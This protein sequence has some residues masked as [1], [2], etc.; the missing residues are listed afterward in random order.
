MVDRVVGGV[1]GAKGTAQPAP[2][3][4]P[5]T[6]ADFPG[7]YAERMTDD[8]FALEDR[9]VEY[10]DARRDMAYICADNSGAH[11]RPPNRVAVLM[12]RVALARGAAIECYGNI[13]L[14]QRRVEPDADEREEGQSGARGKSGKSRSSERAGRRRI[15]ERAM[16]ADQSIFLDA[17]GAE[18]LRSQLMV[19][20]EHQ[21][22]DVVLEV[23]NTTDVRRKKLSVYEEWAFPEV[24]V[25][26]PDTPAKSR[27]K[28]RKSGLTIYQLNKL[29]R[30][31]ETPASKA[32]P[33]WRNEEIH[34]ALNEGDISISTYN[35]LERTG[36]AL[37]RQEGKGPANDPFL[38]KLFLESR[39]EGR[40]EGLVEGREEGLAEGREEGLAEG[41]EE[42]LA[43]GREEGLA[44]GRGEGLAEGREEGLAEGREEGLAEGR[45]EG[46]AEGREEGLAEGRE[47]GL[48]EGRR[49]GQQEARVQ[50][51]A[52][53]RRVV[54]ER[55]LAQRGIACSPSVF[56]DARFLAAS[57]TASVVDA[58]LACRSAADFLTALGGGT[59]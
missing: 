31:E 50:A 6:A 24:W 47:E 42:G 11:A 16:E 29:G 59:A 43:E 22:P 14:Y 36:L 13:T 28:S 2:G 41:R 17:A 44:E 54:A 48:A 40:E 39:A 35:T 45:E 37:G 18:V 23:D 5:V 8:Q 20:G 10:W 4:P 32:F 9:H 15:W 55:I 3:A 19:L 57:S 34:R 7:C 56:A 51:A 49:E 26:V 21:P 27:A 33:G 52:T 58:A 25:E 30:Y 38:R 53:E 12:H 46:L 1:A